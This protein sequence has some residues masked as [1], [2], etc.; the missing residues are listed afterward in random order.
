MGRFNPKPVVAP[1][2][3]DFYESTLLYKAKLDVLS[4]NSLM[5]QPVTGS[6]ELTFVAPPEFVVSLRNEVKQTGNSTDD[7]PKKRY[8]RRY[9]K[10]N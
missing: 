8:R 6:V 10:N 4:K 9:R 5:K 2:E 1:V 3:G 7:A